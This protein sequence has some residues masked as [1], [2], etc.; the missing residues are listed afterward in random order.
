MSLA[1][2]CAL[3]DEAQAVKVH[4]RAAHDGDEFFVG[5]NEVVLYNVVF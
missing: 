5:A 3:G 2:L 1:E 4:V